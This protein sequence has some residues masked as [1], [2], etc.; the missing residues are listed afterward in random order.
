MKG[1]PA[2]RWP[3]HPR[4]YSSRPPTRRGCPRREADPNGC[5]RTATSHTGRR[6]AELGGSVDRTG[7]ID[8]GITNRVRPHFCHALLIDAA[9]HQVTTPGFDRQPVRQPRIVIVHSPTY[10]SWLN[11]IEIYFR[12]SSAKYSSRMTTPA[13]RSWRMPF[14]PLADATPPLANSSPGS[15]SVKIWSLDS[16]TACFNLN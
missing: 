12:S 10:A 11:Q 5:G 3:R 14:T 13:L 6:P 9:Q 4:R 7:V 15:S 2:R 8:E 1:R 16:A